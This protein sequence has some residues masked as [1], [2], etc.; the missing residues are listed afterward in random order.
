MAQIPSRTMTFCGGT[1]GTQ[2][3]VGKI[4]T[5][6]GNGLGRFAAVGSGLR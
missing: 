4:A 6:L 1:G 3:F 2:G 5:D